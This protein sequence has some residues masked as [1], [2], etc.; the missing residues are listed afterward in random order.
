MRVR[1]HLPA[2]LAAL[3]GLAAPALGAAPLPQL[4]ADE[5]VV[6]TPRPTFA[7]TE[8]SS[9]VPIARYEVFVEVG[10]TAV[11]VA[12]TPAGT[13]TARASVDL[14]DDG[15]HRWF[16]RLVNSSGGVASTPPEA[17][18]EVHVA[19][20]PGAPALG[21]VAGVAAQPASRAFSWAGDRADSLWALLDDAGRQVRAGASP[22]GSGRAVLAG[23]PDGAYVFRVVQ[24]NSAAVEGPPAARAFTV[25]ATPP[26]PLV[27]VPAG[28]AGPFA[29]TGLEPGAIATWRVTE[30]GGA[31]VAGPVNTAGTGA[32]P[33][34]LPPGDYTFE[35]RQTDAAGNVGPWGARAFRVPSGATASTTSLAAARGTAWRRHAGRLAP[36]AGALVG[37]ATAR[38]ALAARPAGHDALQRP[39]LP[40]ARGRPAAQVPLGLPDRHALRPPAPRLPGPGRLL[41]VAR[42]ALLGRRVQRRAPRRQRFLRP[43]EAHRPGVGVGYAKDQG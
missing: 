24:R 37:H 30:P 10:G 9:G 8:G 12:D 27:P 34:A 14:P 19:T 5:A 1:R 36:A 20:T 31:V 39:A 41:R 25:N 33:G 18:T 21:P 29:L 4:P 23:L 16:V 2:A 38:P 35:A 3:L 28:D 15:R 13:L 7:W 32:A 11:H 26:A 43:A 40:R 6:A 17:R 22:T 42:L